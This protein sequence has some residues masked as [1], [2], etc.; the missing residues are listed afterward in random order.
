MPFTTVDSVIRKSFD[1]VV[2]GGG[3]SPMSQIPFCGLTFALQTA[4]LT[5]AVRLSEDPSVSVL[6]LEAGASETFEDPNIDIPG[7]YGK[8]M[9][10][11][12]VCP[13]FA[14]HFGA[15]G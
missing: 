2:I 3:V 12:Q 8:I 5:A 10:N 7:Q 6:V 13:L 9:G 14:S 1:Y 4:G 15:S 11:P